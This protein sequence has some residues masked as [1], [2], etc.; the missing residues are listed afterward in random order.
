[1]T[2]SDWF[3]HY[4]FCL[5]VCVLPDILESIAK[6]KGRIVRTILVLLEPCARMNLDTKTILVYVGLDTQ[7]LI[8]M[9]R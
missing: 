5:D 4:L 6:T 9:L 8:V 2:P 3:A 1:M 7:E